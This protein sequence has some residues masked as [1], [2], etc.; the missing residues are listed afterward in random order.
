MVRYIMYSST[1]IIGS[2]IQIIVLIIFSH[3]GFNADVSVCDGGLWL[4][5]CECGACHLQ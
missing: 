3:I 5:F 2:I 1:N 4:W